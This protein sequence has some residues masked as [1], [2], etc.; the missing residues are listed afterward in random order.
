VTTDS[1][2]RNSS[3][4]GIAATDPELVIKNLDGDVIAGPFTEPAIVAGGVGEFAYDWLVPVDTPL[5]TYVGWWSASWLGDIVSGQDIIQIESTAVDVAALATLA[6]VKSRLELADDDL[7]RDEDLLALVNA[8]NAYVLRRTRF[9]LEATTISGEMHER[10]R[11]GALLYARFRPIDPAGPITARGR[12]LGDLTGWTDLTVEL[13]DPFR[14]TLRVIGSSS[15]Q[16]PWPP[17]WGST[18]FRRNRAT[19]W[20]LIELGYLTDDPGPLLELAGAAADIAA[21]M[22]GTSGGAGVKSEKVGQ[23]S[24]EF[25][26]SALSIP[27]GAALTLAGFV[28][29][30]AW[31]S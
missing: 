8:A 4:Q 16:R 22:D 5:A 10:Y 24:Q 15:T 20:P 25:D 14:G 18:M 6:M 9:A 1:V 29:Q 21:G 17:G 28:D 30:Q 12:F 23:V 19:V 27:A 26:T 11:E 7:S 31:M 2:F 13:I 3:N